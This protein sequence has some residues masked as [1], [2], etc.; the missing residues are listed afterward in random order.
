MILLDTGASH[1]FVD[2]SLVETQLLTERVK[3]EVVTAG[4][5]MFSLCEV[6]QAIKRD[7]RNFNF[8]LNVMFPLREDVLLGRNLMLEK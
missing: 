6:E 2:K 8:R 3:Q 4:G 7:G 5:I 1:S